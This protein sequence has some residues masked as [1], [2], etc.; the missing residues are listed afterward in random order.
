MDLVVLWHVGS[1]WTKDRTRVPC[2][3]RW[4]LNHWT[5][6]KVLE[7]SP[8][9][10]LINIPLYQEATVSLSI[11]LL[12]LDLKFPVFYNPC[13]A[14]KGVAWQGEGSLAKGKPRA[15]SPGSGRAPGQRGSESI[16]ADLGC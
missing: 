10:R 3:G 12:L 14:A 4:I 1:S 2:I 15:L 5:T 8:F 7:F 6:K 16:C 9:L 13:L 11:P